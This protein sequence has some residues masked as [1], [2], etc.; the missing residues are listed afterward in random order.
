MSLYKNRKSLKE[1]QGAE[2]TWDWS[3][4]ADDDDLFPPGTVSNPVSASGPVASS[5]KRPLK[6]GQ[7]S[8]SGL[9]R[10][11]GSIGAKDSNNAA[12][13]SRV[14]HT[15]PPPQRR[16]AAPSSTSKRDV[17]TD[18]S[19]PKPSAKPSS[20][21]RTAM[22][23]AIDDSSS[24]DEIEIVPHR[25][26]NP[27]SARVPTPTAKPLP[28]EVDKAKQLE[29]SRTLREAAQAKRRAQ[30]ATEPNARGE[31]STAPTKPPVPV[32]AVK[33]ETRIKYEAKIK[34]EPTPWLASG[35]DRNGTVQQEIV[36]KQ[37]IEAIQR[38]FGTVT[39]QGSS[40][41]FSAS[42]PPP[43][44]RAPAVQKNLL[45]AKD[46]TPHRRPE[47]TNDERTPP[48]PQAP[49]IDIESSDDED[50]TAAIRK[51][52]Q[53]KK[54]TGSLHNDR[55]TTNA[56][57]HQKSK[58][59][60][61]DAQAVTGV[62]SD[63]ASN[64]ETLRRVTAPSRKEARGTPS[65][66]RPVLND[67]HATTLPTSPPLHN[68][69][70]APTGGSSNSRS[71]GLDS[72]QTG[73]TATP[74]R[75]VKDKTAIQDDSPRPAGKDSA[76]SSAF[77]T[78]IAPP[79]T[80]SEQERQ[81]RLQAQQDTLDKQCQLELQ[82]RNDRANQIADAARKSAAKV[83]AQEEENMRRQSQAKEAS[84]QLEKARLAEE[85]RLREETTRQQA[86]KVQQEEE[87]SREAREQLQELQRKREAVQKQEIAKKKAERDKKAELALATEP[88]EALRKKEERI[89]NQQERNAN[90]HK[91]DDDSDDEL[92]LENPSTIPAASKAKSLAALPG[93]DEKEQ[94]A[95]SRSDGP[96]Q[97]LSIGNAPRPMSLN[98]AAGAQAVAGASRHG[99][100]SRSSVCPDA[101]KEITSEDAAIVHW[102][103]TGDSMAA[104]ATKFESLTKK[105]ESQ[106]ALKSRYQL[107]KQVLNSA[108]VSPVLVKRLMNGDEDAKREVNLKVQG[109]RFN[110]L[111]VKTDHAQMQKTDRPVLETAS[112]ADILA[113]D[114][115]HHGRL[116]EI[117]PVDAML[118]RWKDDEKLSWP[119]IVDLFKDVTGQVKAQDTL[120]KR[121]LLLRK[122]FELAKVTRE[123]KRLLAE[124]DYDA[125]KDVND[126]IRSNPGQI[127]PRHITENLGGGQNIRPIDA[128]LVSWRDSDLEWSEVLVHY[129][130]A[131]GV[132]RSESTLR[133][134]Y[135]EVKKELRDAN[136]DP[137]LIDL[138]AQ[139]DSDA[140]EK[141]RRLVERHRSQPIDVDREDTL[142][143]APTGT[144]RSLP[145]PP[146]SANAS[147]QSQP[148]SPAPVL[149]PTT[150]GKALNG[151][152]MWMFQQHQAEVWQQSEEDD[153]ISLIDPED[154]EDYVY[155]VYRVLRREHTFQDELNGM[156]IDDQEWIECSGEFEDI[157]EA[158]QAAKD[159]AAITPI[160]GVKFLEGNYSSQSFVNEHGCRE[161]WIKNEEVGILQIVVH[162]TLRCYPDRI[163]PESKAHWASKSYFVVYTRTETQSE[164]TSEEH[165]E[166]LDEKVITKTVTVTNDILRGSESYLLEQANERA[167]KQFAKLTTKSTGRL[168]RDDDNRREAVGLLLGELDEDQEFDKEGGEEGK[169]LVR[170][171]VERISPTG[172]RN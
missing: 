70:G 149:R 28:K 169:G 97:G 134:R 72:T 13:R 12:K 61:P 71:V 99:L 93:D 86:L 47:P 2:L 112:I 75:M 130:E 11:F 29:L 141:I 26:G 60:A 109:D 123:Q 139:G 100:V 46:A 66:S 38:R 125:I 95:H 45:G 7:P 67:T 63:R 155:N 64:A 76:G 36:R 150:G 126:L 168:D 132:L 148:E 111:A 131:T 82:Q 167:A 27:T 143:R 6:N 14:N 50:L 21:S 158:N 135:R 52:Q 118:L 146:S 49:V 59:A 144:I 24:D 17:R 25:K 164:A 129:E 56:D 151:E 137:E 3:G 57:Q 74:E 107:T 33:E 110:K 65:V 92:I 154:P 101:K 156:L 34:N 78:S 170:V 16:V 40:S 58:A 138:L 91:E 114:H 115:P 73:K 48:K 43:T 124:R 5:S 157:A 133:T 161:I 120:R 35:S 23:F 18:A 80:E 62:S 122:A 10:S 39:A 87:R 147:F 85:R 153:G 106:E 37:R 104:I 19:K 127:S 121:I 103:D 31:A 32:N 51:S 1:P 79:K 102:K 136:V 53:H 55:T 159:E 162:R 77:R 9:K 30:A 160:G 90:L 15:S 96:M 171:W 4:A 44:Q 163:L 172:P 20:T 140:G 84:F 108:Q 69:T 166:A 152:H 117:R 22:P 98:S 83:R 145:T 128:K 116:Q 42:T 54:P 68:E 81:S 119:Q 41:T 8:P 165:D 113:R 142:V 88:A 105:H 94:Q 89:R